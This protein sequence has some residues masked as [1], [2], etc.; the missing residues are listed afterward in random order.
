MVQFCGAKDRE[1]CFFDWLLGTVLKG[2]RG[3]WQRAKSVD[4]GL[5]AKAGSLLFDDRA[6]TAP[7]TQAGCNPARAFLGVSAM[8]LS[9]TSFQVDTPRVQ[10]G[11]HTVFP[12]CKW[13]SRKRAPPLKF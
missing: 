5:L 1:G 3:S 10:L 12:F 7:L 4:A 11:G 2:E 6:V 9:G 8:E 13:P